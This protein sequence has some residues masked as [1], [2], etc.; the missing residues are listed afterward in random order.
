MWT[1]TFIHGNAQLLNGWWLTLRLHAARR[2][3]AEGGVGGVGGG[4]NKPPSSQSWGCV[5]LPPG[6]GARRESDNRRAATLVLRASPPLPQIEEV[7]LDR[8]TQMSAAAGLWSSHSL[9]ELG[10][11]FPETGSG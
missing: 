3:Y 11:G 5:S 4:R 10:Q 6:R 8:T 7:N 1:R 2:A 9:H